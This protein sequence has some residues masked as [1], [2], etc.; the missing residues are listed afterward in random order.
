MKKI[1]QKNKQKNR[2]N[3]NQK[4][5]FRTDPKTASDILYLSKL[6]LVEAVSCPKPDDYYLE[7]SSLTEKGKAVLDN[8]ILWYR[9]RLVPYAAIILSVIAIVVSVLSLV[10]QFLQLSG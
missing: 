5:V 2:K 6:G 7:A 1:S 8:K 10:L 4:R 3:Y 9:D